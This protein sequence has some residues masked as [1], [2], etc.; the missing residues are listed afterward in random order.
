MGTKAQEIIK[1][2][3]YPYYDP[4]AE[5]FTRFFK[6]KF[7]ENLQAVI[8]YGSQLNGRIRYKDS[9]YDFYL[10]ADNYWEF[11]DK[12]SLAILNNFFP[13]NVFNL[14]LEDEQFGTLKG[15]YSVIS[16]DRLKIETSLKAKDNFLFGRFSQRFGIIYAKDE[17][18]VDTIS[19]YIYNALLTGIYKMVGKL[20]E[21]FTPRDYFIEFLK[22]SYSGE[23]RVESFEKIKNTYEADWEYYDKIL[24]LALDEFS[25]KYKYFKKDNYEKKYYLK[26]PPFLRKLKNFSLKFFVKKARIRTIIRWFKDMITFENWV[27]Y[28]IAKVE[29]HTGVKIELTPLERKYPLILGWPHLIRLI[30]SKIVK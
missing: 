29:R 13:P 30:R 27:D 8:L 14:T 26:I 6:K 22:T 20:P 23:I 12:K 17:K 21:Q 28:I 18:I 15:K 7:G 1:N 4:S 5:V 25:E 24:E 2:A 11:Y 9:I 19:Q 16:L 10:I 3:C